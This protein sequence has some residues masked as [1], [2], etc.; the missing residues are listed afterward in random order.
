MGDPGWVDERVW[1]GVVIGGVGAD[2]LF[3]DE[4]AGEAD[5]GKEG[6]SKE[7]DYCWWCSWRCVV[8][9]VEEVVVDVTAFM[10][11]AAKPSCGCLERGVL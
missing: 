2:G 1:E 4:G 11:K 7:H 3:G 5:E 6:G 9:E 8:E 10:K